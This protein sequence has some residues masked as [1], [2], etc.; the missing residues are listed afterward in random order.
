MLTNLLALLDEGHAFSQTELA[1]RLG[2]GEDSVKAQ[3]EYLERRGLLRRIDS[4]S[5]CEGCGGGCGNSC[6]GC[7]KDAP[8]GPAMWEKVSV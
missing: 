6:G 1:Q 5:G 4:G 8:R 2:T 3:M 7:A